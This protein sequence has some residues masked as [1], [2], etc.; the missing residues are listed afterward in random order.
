MLTCRTGATDGAQSARHGP[1]PT[2]S[3]DDFAL[4]SRGVYVSTTPDIEW[5]LRQ[6]AVDYG[7]DTRYFER[8]A[9]TRAFEPGD[10]RADLYTT[11]HHGH[12]NSGHRNLKASLTN[13]VSQ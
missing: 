3:G 7:D 5:S 8:A 9:I 6:R 11:G 13:L 10:L 2:D 12:P 4:C 1:G